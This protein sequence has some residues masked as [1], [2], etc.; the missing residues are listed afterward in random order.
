MIRL[1]FGLL[2][3]A[4][5]LVIAIALIG[6]PGMAS[7]TWLGWQVNTTAAAA[8]LAIGLLAFA[9][10]V[11]WRAVIWLLQSPARARGAAAEA[12]RR[13][14]REALTKGF[15]AAAAG[16]GP[17]ARRHAFRAAQYSDEA[18]Q[19]VRLLAARAAEAAQDGAAAQLAY[20]AM[21]GFPDMR[22]AA[23]RGLMQIAVARGDGEEA[24][25][26]ARAAF[27]LAESA[28]WAW[29]ALL[30]NRLATGDWDGGLAL[31]E[32]ALGR[33]TV[34]PL[35]ADRA[36]AALETA[37][38]ASLEAASTTDRPPAEA[39]DL[40]TAAARARPDFT[41]AAVI[42]ARLR[43][44][45]GRGQRAEAL[46][47]AAWRA[48]PHPALWRAWRDL[49]PDET[50]PARA[51]RLA[52][53]AAINP[54]HRESRILQVEQALIR[55]DGVAALAAAR[56]LE[57]EPLTRRLADLQARLRLAVG[58]PSESRDWLARGATAP[59]EADWSDIGEDGRAFT[60]SPADWG[61]VVG[62]YAE[63]GD[64]LHPRFE[65]GEGAYGELPRIPADYVESEPFNATPWREAAEQ[66]AANA[67]IFDDDDFGAVL[68]AGDSMAS[69]ASSRALGGRTKGR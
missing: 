21:L 35:I 61:R 54:D 20:E 47:E 50:P 56:A 44:R 18:P 26:Q 24:L 31:I 10:T 7:V 41:P 64:L 19:L 27:S 40:A 36:R 42:A 13:E 43:T 53:L 62:A 12:R 67:P 30:E 63:R 68:T 15:L 65:R 48:R 49:R 57:G 11:F 32:T 34:S 14:G 9:A 38:A 16:D 60:Y 8:V 6:E 45:E 58:R 33:K 59:L 39:I 25:R 52:D 5:F 46:L 28:P 17:G 55:G 23:H 29:Q 1:G 22:L 2:L 66:G 4:V 51:R 37:K 3:V 69:P